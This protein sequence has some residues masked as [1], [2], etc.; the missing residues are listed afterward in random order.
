M[1]LSERP[2][3]NDKI[4]EGY[5][6][7]PAAF[8]TTAPNPIFILASYA[9]DL[10]DLYH[11]LGFWEFIPHS[12]LITWLGHYVC[13]EDDHPIWGSLC[14]NVAFLL[15]GINPEQLNA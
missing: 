4:T 2:E 11:F 3:Y 12:W 5:L 1:L 14:L 7:A 8:M 10:Q 13:N 9:D 6:L 15:M